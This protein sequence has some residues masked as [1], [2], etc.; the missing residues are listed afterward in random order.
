MNWIRFYLSTENWKHQFSGKS[1][2]SA[3]LYDLL[4]TIGF[5]SSLVTILSVRE[6]IRKWYIEHLL[7]VIFTFVFVALVF[8]IV[9]SRPR[10]LAKA[11]ISGTDIKI[12]IRVCDAFKIANAALVIPH[13]RKFDCTSEEIVRGLESSQTLQA[14]LVNGYFS[15]DPY[16]LS[17]KL[18]DSIIQERYP[19]NEIAE[20]GTTV[21]LRVEQ[22][23]F[24]I[25]ASSEIDDRGRASATWENTQTALKGLWAYVRDHGDR[26]AVVIPIL[27][28]GDARGPAK[29]EQVILE[30]LKTFIEASDNKHFCSRLII[31]VYFADAYEV[32]FLE[33]GRLL[34]LYCKYIKIS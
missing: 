29:K 10:F 24:Y 22:K 17:S 3:F 4:A 20:L 1:L 25:V 31:A 23:L 30:I 2:R 12:E 11:S 33:L 13:N 7:E 8:A 14:Q 27:G 32:N 16:K 6:E 28:T 34:K 26:S 15:K 9:R 5:L 19:V 21:S 18:R